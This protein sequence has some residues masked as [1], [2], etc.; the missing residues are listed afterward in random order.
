MPNHDIIC[1]GASAGGLEAL[2]AIIRG[3]EEPIPAAVF[4]VIHSLS[5]APSSL[6]FIL[7]RTDTVPAVHPEDGAEIEHGRIYAAPPDFHMILEDSRVRLTRH[8][9]ENLVRP[10]IDP[11]FR[12][13]ART[14]GPRTVGVV[15]SGNL[16]DGTTGLMAIRRSG[17]VAIAQDPHEAAYQGMPRSA[18]DNGAVDFILSSTEISSKLWEL[19]NTPVDQRSVGVVEQ[20]DEQIIG[21]DIDAQID[22][23]RKNKPSTLVCP[24]CGG[25]LWEI[26]EGSMVRYRCHVGHVMS[27]QSLAQGITDRTED[28]LWSAVRAL[29]EKAMLHRRLASL[30]SSKRNPERVAE[31]EK[32][33]EAAEDHANAVLDLLRQIPQKA[34]QK[35]FDLGE[36]VK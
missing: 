16:D 24:D 27:P 22:G 31:A 33:A 6:P 14:Y 1:F 26:R 3:W 12:T 4:V 13:A 19:A 23:K 20:L 17:G 9:K 18:I 32:M 30:T 8:A 5:D 15:L 21:K 2:R 11:L 28:S 10:A 25:V 35:D 7:S 29:Q 34:K 36:D